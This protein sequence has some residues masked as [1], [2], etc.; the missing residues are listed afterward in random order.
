MITLK[1]LSLSLW[2]VIKTGILVKLLKLHSK[3]NKALLEILQYEFI[4]QCVT[5]YTQNL[6]A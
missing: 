4:Y 5:Y 2:G 1:L 6:A 3:I